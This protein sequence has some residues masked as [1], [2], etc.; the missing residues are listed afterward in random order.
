MQMNDKLSS[1]MNSLLKVL[2]EGNLEIVARA[3][4]KS[5]LNRPSDKWSLSNRIIMLVSGTC[6][7]RG[8]QQWHSANRYVRSGSKAL[9]ILGPSTRKIKDD[10]GE[11]VVRVTGF[12]TI[13]VFRLEDTD[14]EELEKDDFKLE[15]PARFGPII[16]E[17]GLDIK[18]IPFTGNCYGWYSPGMIRLATPE[19]KTFLHELC[20]AVDDKLHGIKG[21]QHKDQEIVA[22]FGAAVLARLLGYEIPLGNTKHYLECYGSLREV[23]QFFS[24]I[25]KI[26]GFIYERAAVE[27]PQMESQETRAT[28]A[29]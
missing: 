28:A 19:I 10:N 8:F 2:E 3:V 23:A 12:H 17:L 18:A 29:A 22:E 13:P 27:G 6:D 7:A 1:A 26:L 14:G 15:I 25:E 11:E 5:N 4:F 16:A 20:H 9:Y 21:G 24:R